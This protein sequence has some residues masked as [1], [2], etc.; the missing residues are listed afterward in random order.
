MSLPSDEVVVKVVYK[1][2]DKAGHD[3]RLTL[4]ILRNKTED[5][6]SLERS[7]LKGIRP[8]I[9]NYVYEWWCLR[10]KAAVDTIKSLIRL[11]RVSGNAGILSDLK[12]LPMSEQMQIIRERFI[13]THTAKANSFPLLYIFW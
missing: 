3:P 11:C 4:R 7:A 6:L 8:Q 13:K 12:G 9:K 10:E 5:R 2:L 1:L